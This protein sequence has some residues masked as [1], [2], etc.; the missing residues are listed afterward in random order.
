MED[1]GWY[2]LSGPSGGPPAVAP[3]VRSS[4]L[5]EDVQ[6]VDPGNPNVTIHR[7][8]DGTLFEY[9]PAGLPGAPTDQENDL[10]RLPR[11]LGP[12]DTR[13][14][15]PRPIPSRYSEGDDSAEPGGTPAVPVPS[16]L[17]WDR[18]EVQ[19]DPGSRSATYRRSNR[20]RRTREESLM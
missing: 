18:V 13:T 5:D 20:S 19:S 15:E 4:L 10:L 7:G 16:S 12:A 1:G 6:L 17:L 3:L 9:E 14:E 2:R 11:K 8:R